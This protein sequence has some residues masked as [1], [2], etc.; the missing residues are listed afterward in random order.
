M[1][2]HLDLGAAG[3]TAA[4]RRYEHD[5]FAVLARNWRCRD[6]ELDLV[7]RRGPLLVVC[8][9]K[10]RTRDGYGGGAAAVDRRR[11][12]RLRRATAAWLAESRPRGVTDVR[13]DVAVVRP[14]PEGFAVEVI[15]GA[16]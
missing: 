3:E 13:F 7:L 2:E 15:P 12:I 8:E 16:F 5:G 4:A 10:T 9:V 14:R 1:A 11:Q 6:G